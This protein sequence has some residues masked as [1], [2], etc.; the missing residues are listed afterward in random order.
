[1]CLD[2]DAFVGMEYATTG[3]TT[4]ATVH[5]ADAIY[6]AQ[7]VVVNVWDSSRSGDK[8][9]QPGETSQDVQA[10]ISFYCAIQSNLVISFVFLCISLSSHHGASLI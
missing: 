9:L 3:L 10:H 7:I 5:H 6:G 4:A 8:L 2:A 1:M